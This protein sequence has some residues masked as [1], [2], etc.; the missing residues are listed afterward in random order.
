MGIFDK[1]MGRKSGED[2]PGLDAVTALDDPADAL[3][4]I[5][6]V[7]EVDYASMFGEPTTTPATSSLD[8]T[9]RIGQGPLANKQIPG[10]ES[11]PA[12]RI[13]S[14]ARSFQG[15]PYVWGGSTPSGF[16]CSGFTQYVFRKAGINL[17]RVSYQQAQAGKPVAFRDARAGDLVAWDNSTRNNGAD[18]I[19]VFLGN[20]QIAEAPRPGVPLRIRA[21]GANEGAWIRRVL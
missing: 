6:E 16:D 4:M 10:G 20:G 14:L 11:G 15:T 21:L 12:S 5:S 7:T 1:V 2:A 19:A 13:V 3:G 8:G 18:H 17:P 9:T